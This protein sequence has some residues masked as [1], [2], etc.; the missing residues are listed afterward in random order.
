MRCVKI[1]LGIK[2]KL[3]KIIREPFS[4]NIRGNVPSL[5][6]VM[7]VELGNPLENFKTDILGAMGSQLDAL[8]VKNRQD[9]E[10]A[11]MSIFCPRC[12]TKHPQRVC[13]LNNIFVCHIYIED[14]Q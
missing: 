1:I 7:R 12:R 2:G 9:E 11:T 8:E 14:I 5:G 6:R 4:R 10:R 13:P 3:Q